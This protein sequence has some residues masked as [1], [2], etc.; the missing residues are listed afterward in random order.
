M[1]SGYDGPVVD[2]DAGTENGFVPFV[3]FPKAF[4]P[5]ELDEISAM[6]A[7]GRGVPASLHDAGVGIHRPR[8]RSS[9]VSWIREGAGGERLFFK[10]ASIFR[11]ANAA[12]FGFEIDRVEGAIQIAGYGRF[13]EFSWHLDMGGG[14]LRRRKLT[15]VVQLSDGLD[16][17]GGDLQL[18]LDAEPLSIQRGRGS[19][20]VFPTFILHRVTPV[21]EG[22]RRTLTAWMC[23]PP[24]R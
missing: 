1:A 5:S 22:H 6:V 16:Y 11:H 7:P 8:S 9:D 18:L 21:I 4:G 17:R 3:A 19:A 20:V 15:L 14:K 24:L 23:G 13:D 12:H 2:P 10:I